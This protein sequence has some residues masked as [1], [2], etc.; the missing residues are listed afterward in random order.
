MVVIV[1]V[2]FLFFRTM[3]LLTAG[4]NSFSSRVKGPY[5]IRPESKQKKAAEHIP[6]KDSVKER[7]GGLT[8]VGSGVRLCTVLQ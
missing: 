3:I 1:F 7:P 2:P 5:E 4:N 8:E 6:R